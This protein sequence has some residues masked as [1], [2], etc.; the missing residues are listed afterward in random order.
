MGKTDGCETQNRE[1][2]ERKKETCW[3]AALFPIIGNLP[4]D[5][6]TK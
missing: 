2:K 6:E 5:I 1:I 3:E 4:S